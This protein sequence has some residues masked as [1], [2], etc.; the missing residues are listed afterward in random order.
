[1]KILQKVGREQ[2]ISD[3][4]KIS[5]TQQVCNLRD[6]RDKKILQA[7]EYFCLEIKSVH[8]KRKIKTLKIRSNF[9]IESYQICYYIQKLNLIR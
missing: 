7:N 4:Y 1:M 2:K 3:I 9:S 5:R 8:R 6:L